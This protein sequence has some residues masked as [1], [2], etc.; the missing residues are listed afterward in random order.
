MSI[1]QTCK[2]GNHR[3]DGIDVYIYSDVENGIPLDTQICARCL[4]LH[5]KKYRPGSPNYLHMLDRHPEW[6]QAQTPEKAE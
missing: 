6:A 1:L 2:P 5:L 4:F 3:V